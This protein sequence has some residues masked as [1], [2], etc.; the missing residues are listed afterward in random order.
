MT[1]QPNHAEG[2]ALAEKQFSREQPTSTETS[3][4]QLQIEAYKALAK[5]MFPFLVGYLE[6][7]REDFK[8]DFYFCFSMLSVPLDQIDAICVGTLPMP[9]LSRKAP[10]VLHTNISAGHETA[11]YIRI[12]IYCPEGGI[13]HMGET[14]PTGIPMHEIGP[15]LMHEAKPK[16]SLTYPWLRLLAANMPA[17]Q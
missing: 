8:G 14:T 12:D 2:W 6:K 3:A 17:P 10:L 9:A 13:M 5:K 15:Y 4:L 16:H 11:S 7:M 1:A